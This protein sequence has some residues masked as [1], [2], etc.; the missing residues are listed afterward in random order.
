M[1]EITLGQN[2]F[3]IL[4]LKASLSWKLQAE[5]MPALTCV[6]PLFEEGAETLNLDVDVAQI[7]PMVREFFSQMPP[8]KFLQVT[9]E[10]LSTT[11]CNNMMLFAP[12]GS[13]QADVFDTV[14][15]GKMLEVWELLSWSI[16]VNYADFFAR[17]GGKSAQ[18][19]AP[20]EAS[21]GA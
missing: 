13:G 16:R 1:K 7:V 9:R 3:R 14:F 20:V 18:P 5:I 10:L 15:Q 8:D 12:P 21:S 6:A 4:P 11:A 19:S 2:V 17:L